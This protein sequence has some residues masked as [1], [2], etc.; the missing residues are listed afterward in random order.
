[1]QTLNLKKEC[2]GYYSKA[3]DNISIQLSCPY[4]INEYGS[5]YWQL[6]IVI[7]DNSVLSEWFKTKK[8]A[9]SNGAK[10]VVNNL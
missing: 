9:M 10:W 3:I 2:A 6:T 5:K 1:M 4:L 7:D 8:E